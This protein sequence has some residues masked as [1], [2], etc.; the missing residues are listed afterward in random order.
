MK[1]PARIEGDLLLL[2]HKGYSFRDAFVAIKRPDLL[3]F[4]P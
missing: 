3:E 1:R 4:L 2:K